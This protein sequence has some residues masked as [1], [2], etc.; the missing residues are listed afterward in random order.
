MKKTWKRLIGIFVLSAFCMAMAA[1]S[2]NASQKPAAALPQKKEIKIAVLSTMEP[3]AEW[4]KE[5]LKPQGYDVKVV[6]FDANQLPATALKDGDVDGLYH[7]H[8]PWIKTFNEK[9][10]CNLVM[11]EPYLCYARFAVYSAKHKK[12]ADIPKNARIAVPGDPA[13]MDL[14]LTILRDMKLITLGDKTGKFYTLLD[15]K[16][17]P[18][19]IRI[20]ETEISQTIRSINDVDAVIVPSQRAKMAGIDWNAY[21]HEY[22]GARNYPMSLVVNAKDKEADWVKAAMKVMQTDDFRAKFNAHYQGSYVLF[23][24]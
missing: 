6:M 1:C 2:D 18:K 15:I 10:N 22:P 24:K 14:S 20:I 19:N 17:N 4:V 8:L 7:N 21:L 9:N 13:N 12:V 3:V 23:D 11:P 5:G 16:D